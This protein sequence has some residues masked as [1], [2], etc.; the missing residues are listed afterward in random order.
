MLR[1]AARVVAFL[2]SYAGTSSDGRPA[3][4][5]STATCPVSP[6]NSPRSSAA[7]SGSTPPAALDRPAS[8]LAEPTAAAEQPT[9]AAAQG[10]PVPSSRAA[11]P[12]ATAARTDSAR[13]D[14]QST[15]AI[16]PPSTT[17]RAPNLPSPASRGRVCEPYAIVQSTFGPRVGH[18]NV[19]NQNS[20]SS[21]HGERRPT[22]TGRTC[23]FDLPLTSAGET[24]THRDAVS[25]ASLDRVRSAMTRLGVG[26]GADSS[27]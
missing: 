17:T 21:C 13:R 10:S 16:S 20:R 11:A 1:W 25:S 19:V 8:A 6:G 27:P 4:G 5:A 14:T 22:A 9:R 3:G 15:R 7:A 2:A 12:A 23:W 24:A 26:T 18:G